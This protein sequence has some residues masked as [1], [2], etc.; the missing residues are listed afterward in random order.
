MVY[1]P[2][3]NDKNLVRGDSRRYRITVRE[4]TT[5]AN[6]D[7]ARIDL[8]GSSLKFTM[9]REPEQRVLQPTAAPVVVK[10]SDDLTQIEISDQTLAATLGQA[11]IKLRPDDTRFL[12]PG[13][14]VY[15]VQMTTA[16]GDVYTVARGRIFLLADATSAEDMTP[17]P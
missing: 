16:A 10:D 6:P 12:D 11:V 2:L 9:K 8:T 5:G 13:S 3:C 7:P 4:K 14:Y 15:D 1:D 17:P